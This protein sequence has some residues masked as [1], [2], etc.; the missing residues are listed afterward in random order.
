[1]DEA[2]EDAV[3]AGPLRNGGVSEAALGE[4]KEFD[5]IEL[6]WTSLRQRPSLL[7]RGPGRWR[8]A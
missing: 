8:D 4:A 3:A 7:R 6:T 1:M 5:N 2:M